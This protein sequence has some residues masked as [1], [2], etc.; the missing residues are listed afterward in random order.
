MKLKYWK[1]IT[2]KGELVF[3]IFCIEGKI[4]DIT[5]KFKV[6][7]H[8]RKIRVTT[9]RIEIECITSKLVKG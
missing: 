6:N 9:K 7:V 1:I 4:K 2:L 8:V 5:F 3:Y